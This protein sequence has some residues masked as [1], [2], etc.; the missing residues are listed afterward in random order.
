MKLSHDNI[1]KIEEHSINNG[2]EFSLDA[3][4]VYK[5]YAEVIAKAEKQIITKSKKKRHDAV[6]YQLESLRK[7]LLK[8]MH[9]HNNYSATGI[10]EGYVYLITNPAWPNYVKIGSA[11]DVNDR[12]S[13]YQTSSPL[14]DFKLEFYFLSPDR[15]KDEKA[16]HE[17]CL[18]RNSEWCKIEL[19]TI[20]SVCKQKRAEYRLKV[21][22][23][24]Y[25]Y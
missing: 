3:F 4:V 10:K 24:F 13:S 22:E 21:P 18:E 15:L 5:L 8:L 12:L 1:S 25:N 7:D 2:I 11:I 20:K 19:D 6:L 9:K 17:L 14:R 23:K 16:L